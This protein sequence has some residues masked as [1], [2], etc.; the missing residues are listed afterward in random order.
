MESK[1]RIGTKAFIIENTKR[2]RRVTVIALSGDLYTL[3]FDTGGGT[4][5]R[6][7]RIYLS[8]DDIPVSLRT[9]SAAP[10]RLHCPH[11]PSHL[12]IHN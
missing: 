6:R 8:M 11:I 4:R 5:L 2:I 12:Y 1:I 9:E 7:S 10:P 3:R